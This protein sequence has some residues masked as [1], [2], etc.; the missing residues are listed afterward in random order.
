M[1]LGGMAALGV[2]GGG[3]AT[4]WL[5]DQKNAQ[6]CNACARPVHAHMRTVALLDGKRANYC[7]PACALSEQLQ[8][9]KPLQV[10]EL[11]DYQTNATLKPES[12]FIV[13]SSDVNPCLHHHPAVGAD[14][15]PLQAHYD[16]CAPSALAFHDQASASAFAAGHGGQVLRYTDFAAGF[17]Q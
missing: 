13:R 3:Y 1:L 5:V 4:W 9:G 6:S 8:S 7:C 11:T 17:R 12:A 10:I 16:R 15:Q 14:S 2:C